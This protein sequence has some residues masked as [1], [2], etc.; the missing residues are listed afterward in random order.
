MSGEGAIVILHGAVPPEAPPEELDTLV[1]VGQVRAALMAMGHVV[2]E[3]P[4][5][6]NLESLR[7][8]LVRLRPVAVFN[9]V[10]S[11][12]A[13]DALLPLAPMVAEAL[14]FVCTGA[15]ATALMVTGDKVQAKHTLR[16]ARIPTPDLWDPA[17]H[18]STRDNRWIVK[19]NSQQA[20]FG[21]DDQCVVPSAQVA[22]RM[23]ECRKRLGGQW[24]AERFIP[25][26]E[27]NLS[28]LETPHG[29]VELPPAEIRFIDFPE[30]KPQIV[31]Y[32]AKWNSAS[33]EY[34]NTSRRF[35]FAAGDQP[36]LSRLRYLA[37]R[38]WTVF[39]LG[40]Y[41]RVD[42]RVDATGM[43]WVLEVNANPCLAKDAGFVATAERGGYSYEKLI[44]TILQTA[45]QR[46]SPSLPAPHANPGA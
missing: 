45:F 30:G 35:G 10:E 28:L 44:S 29:L 37:R 2:H 33:P 46:L 39:G 6:L 15:R 26:R 4:V 22:Q 23:E 5:T 20:S 31:G 16:Q 19:S 11:I 25:G 13:H 24:F 27:F 9:L 7:E 34:H 17:Q 36:L 43:P 21:L 8:A 12:G 18:R 38:A 40:G 41:A 14:G 32:E 3:V 42:F 1:Q